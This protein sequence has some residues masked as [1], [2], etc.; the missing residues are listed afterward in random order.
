MGAG[1]LYVTRMFPIQEVGL[2]NIVVQAMACVLGC[3]TG[4]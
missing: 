1:N 2:T 3:G 4:L